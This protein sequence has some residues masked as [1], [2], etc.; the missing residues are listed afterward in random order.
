MRMAPSACVTSRAGQ[1]TRNVWRAIAEAKGVTKKITVTV[2][3]ESTRRRSEPRAL[4]RTYC[5]R[6]RH[7]G[8]EGRVLRCDT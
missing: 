7:E 4:P 5:E 2:N 1:R 8:D 6:D 3:G